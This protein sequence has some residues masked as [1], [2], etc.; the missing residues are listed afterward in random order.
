MDSKKIRKSIARFL[1]WIGLIIC[2]LIIKFT[3]SGY[4]YGLA[5]RVAFLGYYLV[6]KQRRIA[7]ESLTIAFGKEKSAGQIQQIAKDCFSS[8]AKSGAEVIFLLDRPKLIIQR[9]SMVGK[10]NLDNMYP[11]VVS[12]W[13]ISIHHFSSFYEGVTR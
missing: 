12:I 6:K 9:V 7:L 10:E 11:P 1:G 13:I 4:I 5:R 8:M 2:S 3:P